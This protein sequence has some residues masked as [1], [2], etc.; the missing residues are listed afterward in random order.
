MV[1][2]DYVELSGEACHLFCKTEAVAVL[3]AIIQQGRYL[4]RDPMLYALYMPRMAIKG[5]GVFIEIPLFPKIQQLS[6]RSS[7]TDDINIPLGSL[8]GLTLANI[9][10][11]DLMS[12]IPISL[13]AEK[14]AFIVTESEPIVLPYWVTK[15]DF[16]AR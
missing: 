3:A 1:T 11:I 2:L 15:G 9:P 14:Y 6:F 4:A 5:G 10:L 7:N 12:A 16:D 13:S 8:F